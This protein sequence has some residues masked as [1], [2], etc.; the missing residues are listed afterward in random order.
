MVVLSVTFFIELLTLFCREDQNIHPE[1]QQ[2][3]RAVREQ[4]QS[5]QETPTEPRPQ[6]YT[7]MSLTGCTASRNQLWPTLL[8]FLY[9]YVLEMWDLAWCYKLCSICKQMVTLLFLLFHDHASLQQV[10]DGKAEPILILQNLNDYNRR[11][12]GQPR[13]LMDRLQEVPTLQRHAFR[14]TS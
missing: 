10:Q 4:L 13:S 2:H 1:N 9:S 8:W 5:E 7:D 6:H 12:L 3:V 11:F 14:D